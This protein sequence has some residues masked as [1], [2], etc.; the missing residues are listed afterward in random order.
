MSKNINVNPDHYK[1]AGRERQGE[2][3]IA[4]EQKQKFGSEHKQKSGDLQHDL[5]ARAEQ[6]NR[7]LESMRSRRAQPAREAGGVP[8]VAK[9]RPKKKPAKAARPD[10]GGESAGGQR[11]VASAGV[12]KV[13]ASPLAKRAGRKAK[14]AVK[15][16]KRAAA[17]VGA[18]A[19]TTARTIAA[20][21]KKS[22]RRR[23]KQALPKKRAASVAASAASGSRTRRGT[24]ARKK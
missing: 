3:V 22:V 18:T 4:S 12:T 21:A 13:A 23:P 24:P 14:E 17:K 8:R 15:R 2:D 19:A 1:V 5:A 20:K 11:R 9:P 10:D 7:S 6:R 16:T